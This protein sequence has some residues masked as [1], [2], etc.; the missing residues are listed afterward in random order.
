MVPNVVLVDQSAFGTIHFSDDIETGINGWTSTGFWHQQDLS[1]SIANTLVP[2]YTSLAP[3]EGGPQAL[4]PSAASGTTAW[5][6]GEASTGTFIGT[7]AAGDTPLSGGRSTAENEGALTSPSINLSTGVTPMLLFSTWWEI[8]SV[9]PNSSGF[10]LL[11]VQISTD[12]GNTFT[13]IKKLNPY[14]DPNDSDRA[15]KPFSS[16]GFNRKPVW[17]IED[18]DLTDYVGQTIQIRFNFDTRDALYNGFRGWVIDDV[19]IIDVS[20]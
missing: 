15:H 1:S 12:N 13:T 18:I 6:Y 9:N 11:E 5:W 16:G 3:D 10:D 7:Q 20:P 8:E 4:L 2:T 17:V 14:V 19:S